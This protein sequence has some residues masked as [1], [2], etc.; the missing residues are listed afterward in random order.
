MW[1]FT[2]HNPGLTAIQQKAKSFSLKTFLSTFFISL[3]FFSNQASAQTN[4][5]NC[6]GSCTSND[7][8]ITEAFLSDINGN[9][10]TSDA[11]NDPNATVDAYLSFTFRNNTQSDRNGIFISGSINGEF[12]YTCFPGILPK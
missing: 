5:T 11:C 9:R 3:L 4:L 1:T 2:I 12:I 8:T 10:I 7:F 6:Y